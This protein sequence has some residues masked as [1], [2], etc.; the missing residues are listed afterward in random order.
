MKKLIVL[1]LFLAIA[2]CVSPTDPTSGAPKNIT[3]EVTGTATTVDITLE[4]ASGGT[5]QYSAV[6]L[7]Y[8]KSFQV[9]GGYHFVYISAQNNGSTGSVTST[10]KVGGAVFKTATSSGA[11]VIATAS[12]S[13]GNY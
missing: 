6:S 11:Y 1:S 9:D 10:I 5:E 8:T 4:N 3:Y 13:V 7:P 2:G 12:G